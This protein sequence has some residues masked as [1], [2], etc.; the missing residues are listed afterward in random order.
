MAR[1]LAGTFSL[2]AVALIA[3]V[4]IRSTQE[5]LAACLP[6]NQDWEAS[7]AND[8]GP[9]TFCDAFLEEGA[10]DGVF[11]AETSFRYCEQEIPELGWFEIVPGSD[12]HIDLDELVY[13]PDVFFPETVGTHCA[14]INCT[15]D[16]KLA[17][18]EAS[19][20]ELESRGVVWTP[21]RQDEQMLYISQ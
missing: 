15:I 4:G 17:P 7:C 14:I 16:G 9:E 13:Y 11:H 5:A 6:C 3:V 10:T 1:F 12:E 20:G 18:P 8:D 21:T 19:T 2:F